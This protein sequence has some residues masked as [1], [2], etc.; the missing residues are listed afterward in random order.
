MSASRKIEVRAAVRSAGL[1]EL[2]DVEAVVL[3]TDGSF[4]VVKRAEGA[5]SSSL[6]EVKIPAQSENLG[7][8]G[9]SDTGSSG[10]SQVENRTMTRRHFLV[11]M[12]SAASA[13]MIH[14]PAYADNPMNWNGYKPRS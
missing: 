1:T 5:E 8:R 14:A 7:R 12:G 11:T 3:E 2:A 13:T 9:A 4:S 10:H 6:S